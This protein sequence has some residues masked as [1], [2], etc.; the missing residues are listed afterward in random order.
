[1]LASTAQAERSASQTFGADTLSAALTSFFPGHVLDMGSEWRNFSARVTA[2]SLKRLHLVHNHYTGAVRI[3]IPDTRFFMEGFPL[4]GSAETVING[5]ARASSGERGVFSEPG[6]LTFSSGSDFENIVL[7]MESDALSRTIMTMTGVS[8]VGGLKFDRRAEPSESHRRVS[9]RLVR[10]LVEELDAGR[11]D[12]SP[13]VTAELEQALLVAFVC[14]HSHNYS[15]LLHGES[16]DAAPWQIRR[17]EEYVAANWDQ[18]LSIEAMAVVANASVR[19]IFNAFKKHRGYS[20]MN[21][22]KKLR[23]EHARDMLRGS[24]PYMTVTNAAYACGFG[25]LGHFARDYDSAFGE[26]P[27]A[28][29]RRARSAGSR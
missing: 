5:I 12:L 17:V 16:P 11:E 29:M 10:L 9:R 15:H 23:L 21:F 20:P 24:Q 3:E 7:M 19:T 14:G 22:V 27:S 26:T 13:L 18:P 6:K 2:H 4:R 8:T 25:N 1:M 28:T